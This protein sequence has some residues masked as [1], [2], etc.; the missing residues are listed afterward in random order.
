MKKWL[1]PYTTC[2][3]FIF[4]AAC[5][6]E[7]TKTPQPGVTIQPAQGSPQALGQPTQV[8]V[9]AAGQPQPT[10]AEP[11]RPAQVAASAHLSGRT[12][13]RAGVP[14]IT[15]TPMGSQWRAAA[16]GADVDFRKNGLTYEILSGGKAYRT[17]IDGEK[18]KVVGASGNLI[19]KLK[20]KSDKT[21][22]YTTD[23]DPT[24]WSVKP[25]EG[26]FKIKK[27]ETDMGKVKFKPEKQQ[28]EVRDSN[29]QIVCTMSG[30]QSLPAP[31]VCLMDNLSLEQQ[32]IAFGLLSLL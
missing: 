31:S 5:G 26:R 8:G 12:L 15:F 7:E 21:K 2:I 17:K 3:I 14:F 23:A 6:G 30:N 11:S 20:M 28:I 24:P 27:G 13:N 19:L 18:V 4:T 10:P 32:L 16:S 29:E 25:K 1:M 9:P 22:I